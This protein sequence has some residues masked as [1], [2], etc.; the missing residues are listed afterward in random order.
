MAYIIFAY[1]LLKLLL[2]GYVPFWDGWA[3]S[4][5]V[6][7]KAASQPF[8]FFNFELVGHSSFI[9]LFLLSIWQYFDLGNIA[10]IHLTVAL[11]TVFSIVAFNRLLKQILDKKEFS[12][13][14]YALT[15]LY[16]FFPII[17]ASSLHINIDYGVMI[18]FIIF[19]NFLLSGKYFLSILAG[20]GMM[21]SKET[22]VGL[23]FLTLGI[24]FIFRLS[25]KRYSPK[26]II[27]N[28]ISRSYFLI[29]PL[30][31]L[32]RVLAVVFF[33]KEGLWFSTF[34]TILKTNF[35]T[36]G[37]EPQV[38]SRIPYSYFLG[39]FIINFNWI[40]SLI[41]LLGIKNLL[42]NRKT[43][44][45]MIVFWG[46]TFFLTAFKT[47]SNLRYFLPL[48]PIMIIL[49]GY[50][51]STFVKNKYWRKILFLGLTVLFFMAN[52]YTLDPVSRRIYSTFDFGKHK[53]LRMTSI[54]G[55]CCVFGRDQL[56]YN[57]ETI[58]IHYLL[59]TVIA[60][61]KPDELTAFAYH[62]AV[63]PEIM[64]NFNK[65][66]FKRTINRKDALILNVVN[67]KFDSL[68]PKPDKIYFI[69][70]PIGENKAEIERYSKNY[71]LSQVKE[72]NL[73]DFQIK[74]DTLVLKKTD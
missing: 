70:F 44:F 26:K 31:F 71:K 59:N 67:W 27:V 2:R 56:I 53:L 41:I 19:L 73:L 47:F 66:N 1:F 39:I 30:L 18:F 25:E 35:A 72:Y 40:L 45:L 20:T 68:Y 23:Y 33:N 62:P 7:Y 5:E 42:K 65:N 34:K 63:G 64:F 14:I 15:I 29:P 9:Y 61:I 6:I 32:L 74:A 52:F 3:N 43:L 58:P 46:S 24:Y 55:E 21:F 16:A 38:L 13:E 8:D 4:G 51:L 54:T 60:D 57:L 10:G 12:W 36:P 49:A 11:L 50:S 17:F 37:F 28:V 48:Y 22:G 69:E